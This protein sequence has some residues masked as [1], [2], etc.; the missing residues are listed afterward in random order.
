VIASVALVVKRSVRIDD[1]S[2]LE[3]AQSMDYVWLVDLSIEQAG[4]SHRD[5]VKIGQNDLYWWLAGW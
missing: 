3:R 4:R 2:N 5:L 1:E